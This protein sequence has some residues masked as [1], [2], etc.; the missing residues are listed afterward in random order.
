MRMG[1]VDK[2]DDYD[3]ADVDQHDDDCCCFPPVEADRDFETV[4][5]TDATALGG[6]HLSRQVEA[7][8]NFDYDFIL[9]IFCFIYNVFCFIYYIE[10]RHS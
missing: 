2:L 1:D 10:F 7:W 4:L 8:K 9:E 5:L 3:G 6:A